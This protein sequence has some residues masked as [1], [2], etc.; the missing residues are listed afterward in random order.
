[1]TSAGHP[2]SIIPSIAQTLQTVDDSDVSVARW[3]ELE[4]GRFKLLRVDL[5]FVIVLACLSSVSD[6]GTLIAR[7][8]QFFDQGHESWR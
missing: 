7:R 8:H 6:Y 5:E 2:V 3:L 4:F 1:M